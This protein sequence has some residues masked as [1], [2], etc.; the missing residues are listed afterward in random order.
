MKCNHHLGTVRLPKI[1]QKPLEGHSRLVPIEDSEQILPS[2]F[3]NAA[4]FCGKSRLYQCLEKKLITIVAKCFQDS[5]YIIVDHLES[6]ARVPVN[7]AWAV[8]TCLALLVHSKLLLSRSNQVPVHC[9]SDGSLVASLANVQAK[10]LQLLEL[11]F[12]GCQVCRVYACMRAFVTC[13][14]RVS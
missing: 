13:A 12:P 10:L 2:S 5:L 6:F 7:I 8:F 11:S 9:R 3:P 14:L 1:H 4:F